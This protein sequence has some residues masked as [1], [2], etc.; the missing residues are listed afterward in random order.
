VTLQSGR[1]YSRQ[2]DVWLD[3]GRTTIIM[4]GG[5][6]GQ[7]FPSQAIIDLSLGKAFNLG[8]GVVFNA[9]LQLYNLLNEDAH[10]YWETL[11]IQ[12]GERFVPDAAWI[13]LP[14][15]LQVRLGIEF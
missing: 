8:G 10:D 15:R 7:R 4:E 3:Q 12:E 2:I 6:D 13:T 1:A 14:R 11:S 5:N 9:D